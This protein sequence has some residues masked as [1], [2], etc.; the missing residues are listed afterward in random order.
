MSEGQRFHAK[1]S[2]SKVGIWQSCPGWRSDGYSSPAAIRGTEIGDSV[3]QG[4][5][6]IIA[7][8]PLPDEVPVSVAV[9]LKN[10][11][12]F[13]DAV[14]MPI[15]CGV[16]VAAE[17]WLDSGVKH[18]AGYADIVVTHP[19]GETAALIEVKT[20]MGERPSA[21]QSLQVA[22]YAAGIL[23]DF[24]PVVHC[25]T[26][27]VDKMEMTTAVYTTEDINRLQWR[28]A[29]TILRH[30]DN[31]A[32]QYAS[33]GYCS[34]CGRAAECPELSSA[35]PQLT[36]S[37]SSG[38]SA[39]GTPAE[40]VSAMSPAAIGSTLSTVTPLFDRAEK[41]YHALKA[42]AIETIEAGG[43][44]PGWEVKHSASP[45]KWSDQGAA[46]AALKEQG[47]DTSHIIELKTPAQV[48]KVL[49]KNKQIIAPYIVPGAGRKSLVEVGE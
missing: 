15:D 42:R 1:W 4:L 13:L 36:A 10:I 27:E 14:G 48:E 38:L 28:L 39:T 22:A 34:Y 18:C 20:G 44:I 25:A 6:I 33:G 47:I 41:Y 3:A 29:T 37:L 12:R 49:G 19:F 24:A 46:M 21:G 11:Q 16:E 45:R 2:P 17:M 40:I 32:G 31:D 9:A 5:G 43:E 26:V 23:R 35:L 30:L 8:K 7:G